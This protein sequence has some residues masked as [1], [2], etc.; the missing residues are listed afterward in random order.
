M[1]VDTRGGRVD[2]RNR[3]DG[4]PADID[5]RSIS[6]LIRELRDESTALFREEIA[7]AKTEM[8]E[9]GSRV[10]RNAALLATGAAVAHLGLIFLLLSASAGLSRFYDSLGM[11][12]HGDWI[13]PLVVGLIVGVIGTIMLMKA[14]KTLSNT[15][16]VPDRTV[17][18][19]RN[20]K[21]WVKE[22]VR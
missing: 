22:K 16:L 4:Q 19:L 21:N 9:K 10:A 6:E 1:S 13:A 3:V 2:G 8:S 18:S 15:S 14:K 17:E 20:D 7:L 12:F 11:W 5:G